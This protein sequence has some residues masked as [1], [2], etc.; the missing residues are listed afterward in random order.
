M[1]VFFSFSFFFPLEFKLRK[2]SNLLILFTSVSPVLRTF[3]AHHL[4]VYLLKEW[5]SLLIF[6]SKW[7]LACYGKSK[8]RGI[9]ITVY[10]ELPA[11]H[12]ILT[13]SLWGEH[14]YYH[15]FT[16]EETGHRLTQ[17]QLADQEHSQ[18]LYWYFG[19]SETHFLT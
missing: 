18:E 13:A 6:C 1:H 15:H 9:R 11:A 5:M 12:L 3:L 8:Q 17:W 16:D 19:K 2:A 14:C 10:E 7:M 4:G